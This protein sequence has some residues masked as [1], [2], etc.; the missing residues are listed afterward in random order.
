MKILCVRLFSGLISPVEGQQE[1]NAGNRGKQGR[2]TENVVGDFA[3]LVFSKVVVKRRRRGMFWLGDVEG[4]HDTDGHT[5][6]HRLISCGPGVTAGNIK[7]AGASHDHAEAVS[8]NVIGRHRTLQ[9]V[10]RGFDTV[11]INDDILGR[12]RKSN[13]QCN[14]RHRDK[15]IRRIGIRDTDQA[16]DDASLT[17]KHPAA[18]LAEK[19]RQNGYRQAVD[20]RRPDEFQRVCDADPAEKADPRFADTPILASQADSV[21]NTRRSGRPAENPRKQHHD[22]ARLQVNPR[23]RPASRQACQMGL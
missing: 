13:Q 11:S 22:D 2:D 19:F 20:D 17:D 23:L 21:P 9:I 1:H 12:R 6:R 7:R 4:R 18:A 15:I 8:K 14:Q 16:A 5:D 3:A 10:R